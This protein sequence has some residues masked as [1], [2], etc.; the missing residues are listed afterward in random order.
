MTVATQLALSNISCTSVAIV[1]Q[2]T[3]WT[4][5]T[6]S[7]KHSAGRRSESWPTEASK[8]LCTFAARGWAFLPAPMPYTEEGASLGLLPL[9][10][11]PMKASSLPIMHTA[12]SWRIRAF[13]DRDEER[14]FLAAPA[15]A[16]L[17]TKCRHRTLCSPG[18]RN[19]SCTDH[20]SANASSQLMCGMPP[21]RAATLPL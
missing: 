12:Q 15:Q 3:N 8:K 19:R 16:V 18:R 11:Q 2:S 21:E 20:T 9:G 6:M 7:T 10:T 4:I 5:P 1:K 17:T 13:N 14:P